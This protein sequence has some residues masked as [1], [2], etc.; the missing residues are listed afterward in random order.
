MAVFDGS[1]MLLGLLAL[2]INGGIFGFIV[3]SIAK[4][5]GSPQVRE[6]CSRI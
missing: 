5:L 2:P 1:E 6:L 3:W 4:F